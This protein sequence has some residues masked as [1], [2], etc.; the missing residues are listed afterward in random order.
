M[1]A[2]TAAPETTVTAARAVPVLVWV[3]MAVLLIAG[4]WLRLY[5]ISEPPF[6]F[7]GQRQLWDATRARVLYYK[8]LASDP[9]RAVSPA[10]L[11]IAQ[12]NDAAPTEPPILETLAVQGYEI[13][14]KED[15]AIPRALSAIFYVAGGIFLFLLA[16]RLF[17]AGPAL[18]ALA[19]YLFL[20]FAVQATRTFQPDPLMVALVTASLYCT[21]RYYEKPVGARLLWAMVVAALAVVVKVVAFPFVAIPFLALAL[22]PEIAL[23]RREKKVRTFWGRLFHPHVLLF[24]A[25]ML[26]GLSWYIY[27]M[28][29]NN[30]GTASQAAKTFM[31]AMFG[32]ANYWLGLYSMLANLT[33][34]AW[35]LLA[36]ALGLLLCRGRGAGRLLWG[37]W[38]AYLLFAFAFNYH[39][40]THSYYHLPL[41]PTVALSLGALTAVLLAAV[42]ALPLRL[43]AALWTLFGGAVLA[44]ALFTAST[45]VHPMFEQQVQLYREIGQ[46]SAL[47]E[48]QKVLMLSEEYGYPLRFYGEL[49]GSWWPVSGD[50]Y[51]EQLRTGKPPLGAAERMAA[52]FPGMEYF[53]ITNMQGFYQQPDLQEYLTSRGAQVVAQSPNYLILDIRGITERQAQPAQ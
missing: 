2:K 32:Q 20:P 3:A 23:A 17:T 40:Q 49:A 22:D 39:T 15:L 45:Q 4:L 35:P 52:F 18:V 21:Y 25:A 44:S 19:V 12:A 27:G 48:S 28:A 34:G 36:G 1:P 10:K 9:L 6:D 42:P 51:A 33:I 26:A 7:H 16:L 43:S 38:I 14:G 13:A 8:A 41:V 31:P 5:R 37:A 24:A 30:V 47:R 29:V 53:V 50:F 46:H 11:A